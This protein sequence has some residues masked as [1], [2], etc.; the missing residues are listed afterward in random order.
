LATE[1]ITTSINSIL[2]LYQIYS[3]DSLDRGAPTAMPRR[4]LFYSRPDFITGFMG[5]KGQRTRTCR[6]LKPAAASLSTA[7]LREVVDVE[8]DTITVIV[9][10]TV[11]TKLPVRERS[12][13]L[14]A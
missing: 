5:S 6:S 14:N 12:L 2:Y 8:R 10:Q 9:A 4:H 11:P 3:C 13:P 1:C 7:K